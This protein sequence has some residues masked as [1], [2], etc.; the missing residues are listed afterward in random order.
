MVVV[1]RLDVVSTTREVQLTRRVANT[2]ARV[3][4]RRSLG[5]GLLSWKCVSGYLILFYEG[6]C[7]ED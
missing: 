7:Y 6:L 4:P 3:N 2:R 5:N 1:K